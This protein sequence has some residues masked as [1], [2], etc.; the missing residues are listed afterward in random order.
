[1]K[2]KKVEDLAGVI[3]HEIGHIIGGHFSDKQKAAEKTGD[4]Y[5]FSILAAGAIAAGAGH[6]V[7]NSSYGQQLGSARFLSFSRSQESLQT[8]MQLDF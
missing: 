4:K 1:M 3:A 6:R 8:K 5:N 7:S 2:S